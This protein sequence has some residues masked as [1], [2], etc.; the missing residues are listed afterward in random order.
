MMS[1]LLLL[2]LAFA[3]TGWEGTFQISVYATSA[4]A[5]AGPTNPTLD[6]SAACNPQGAGNSFGQLTCT[7]TTASWNGYPMSGTCT[8]IVRPFT[9]AV[10]VC[11]QLPSQT[12]NKW[13]MLHNYT[14]C[15]EVVGP[16][17]EWD[18]ATLSCPNGKIHVTDA[19]YRA[20]SA[21]QCGGPV[22]NPHCNHNVTHV[23]GSVC[24]GTTS[25]SVDV[26]N[27]QFNDPCVGTKKE[28]H[29]HNFCVIGNSIFSCEGTTA[30]LSCATGTIDVVSAY[31]GA[32]RG[33]CGGP[34]NDRSCAL[35]VLDIVSEQCDGLTS[36][37]VDVSN[38]DFTDPCVGTKKQLTG[39]YTCA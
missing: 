33:T 2:P 20:E 4:C 26:T 10:G 7:T 19:Y 38:T 37:S 13:A 29:A 3:S 30:S 16:V 28:L 12:Q 36:C 18:T 25:C 27:S 17:C 39:L 9:I 23:V 15:H 32:D 31:Y 6:S 34:V 1:L 5:T 8:G 22:V 14:P 21:G 11:T 35:D 24:D